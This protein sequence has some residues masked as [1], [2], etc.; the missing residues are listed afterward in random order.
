MATQALAT[1][2]YAPQAIMRSWPQGPIPRCRIT[3]AVSVI[4]ISAISPSGPMDDRSFRLAN[5]LVGNGEAAAGLRCTIQG[6][7]LRFHADSVIAL[8]GGEV[9]ATLDE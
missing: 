1:L 6:P 7:S 9:H 4:G 8:C 5:R 3:P 2:D